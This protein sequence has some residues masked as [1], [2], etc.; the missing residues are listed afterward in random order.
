M[1]TMIFEARGRRS[2][3][4]GTLVDSS[5]NHLPRTPSTTQFEQNVLRFSSGPRNPTPIRKA[6]D[7]PCKTAIGYTFNVA[8]GRFVDVKTVR[9]VFKFAPAF[10]RS[11]YLLTAYPIP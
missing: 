1:R 11:F 7:F 2:R 8:T 10:G 3:G 4:M 5:R 6:F 9:I